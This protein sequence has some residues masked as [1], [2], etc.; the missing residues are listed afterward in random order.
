MLHQTGRLYLIPIKITAKTLSQ[1]SCRVKLK[2]IAFECGIIH[3]ES[4]EL[5]CKHLENHW[6]VLKKPWE[7]KY[8]NFNNEKAICNLCDMT[9]EKHGSYNWKILIS[10]QVLTFLAVVHEIRFGSQTQMTTQQGLNCQPY[11]HC[12]Y[13]TR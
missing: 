3:Y 1:K 4:I 2:N 7:Q 8:S 10:S 11:I 5:I 6:N 12:I 9:E 13:P